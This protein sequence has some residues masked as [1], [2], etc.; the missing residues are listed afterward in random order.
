MR[1]R[2]TWLPLLALLQCSPAWLGKDD[3][4]LM[5]AC[6]EGQSYVY[7]DF[8]CEDP[9]PIIW[10]HTPLSIYATEEFKAH[11]LSDLENAAVFSWN[12]ATGLDLFCLECGQWDVFVT[13]KTRGSSLGRT[14]HGI[15]PGRLVAVVEV[16][17]GLNEHDALIVLVHELG[18]VLGLAHD[19]SCESVMY[20]QPLVARCIWGEPGITHHDADL[21]HDL[22]VP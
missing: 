3:N 17:D 12:S 6:L 19:E 10:P 18:H 13:F 11:Y 20:A 2:L 22:Y 8:I 16:A 7:D 21:L 14:Y 9:Q 4:G 5:D 1:H 15:W